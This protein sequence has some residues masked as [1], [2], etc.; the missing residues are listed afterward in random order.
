MGPVETPH[1]LFSCSVPDLEFEK[2]PSCLLVKFLLSCIIW[3]TEL[4]VNAAQPQ[5]LYQV[6]E[7]VSER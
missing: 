5:V 1:D 3:R 2:V 4:F 6:S 7:L